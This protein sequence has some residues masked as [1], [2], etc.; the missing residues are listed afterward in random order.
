[1][2]SVQHTVFVNGLHP[3]MD[4]NDVKYLFKGVAP[5]HRV[6]LRVDNVGKYWERHLCSLKMR[7]VQNMLSRI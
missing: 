7:T 2:D 6:L 1:M 4:Q 5:V 3:D